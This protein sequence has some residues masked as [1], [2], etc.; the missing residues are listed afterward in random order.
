M[1]LVSG[2][3]WLCWTRYSKGHRAVTLALGQLT[4]VALLFAGA[5]A[6]QGPIAWPPVEVWPALL[7]TG[8][9][10]SAA[11]FF[12]QTYAQQRLSAVETGMIILAEPIFAA[13]FGWLLA[14]DRLTGLQVLGAGLMLAA[15][16]VAEMHPLVR[17][18]RNKI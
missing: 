17:K 8:G 3:T 7:L 2:Y 11:A 4:T 6:V 15:V 10:C 13:F 12:V 1:R 9:V 16:F 14:G 18:V 5:W